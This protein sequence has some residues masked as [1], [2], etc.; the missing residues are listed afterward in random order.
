M[1][2]ILIAIAAMVVPGVASAADYSSGP[3]YDEAPAARIHNWSGTYFGAQGGFTQAKIHSWESISVTDPSGLNQPVTVPLGKGSANGASYGGFVGYN[4]QWED[5]VLGFE[6]NY[7]RFDKGAD[8]AYTYRGNYIFDAALGA[9]PAS[10][11][12]TTSTRITDMFGGRFRAGWATGWMMPYA[13]VGVVVA[14]GDSA[15]SM[16]ISNATGTINIPVVPVGAGVGATGWRTDSATPFGFSAALGVDM[17]ITSN[18]FAR[19]EIEYIGLRESKGVA[20]QMTT[21]RAGLGYRF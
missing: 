19:A 11:T 10:I 5:I 9:Q 13:A 16:L 2:K 14:R 7:N 17:A 21:Y 8:Y 20:G 15:T 4:A 3:M 1:R 12:A 18:I 6:F